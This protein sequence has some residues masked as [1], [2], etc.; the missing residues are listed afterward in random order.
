[1]KNTKKG[2]TLVELVISMTIVTI[3]VALSAAMIVTMSKISSKREYEDKCVD[4]YQKASALILD[5]KNAYSI[6]QYS[7]FSVEENEITIKS[8]TNDY[9]LNFN[10]ET[11]TLTAQIYNYE[12][13]QVD[14]KKI[15]FENIINISFVNTNNIVKCTYE[16]LNFHQYTNLLDFGVN[17]W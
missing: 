13:S 9:V 10:L 2:F 16:F 1:M 15:T 3:V 17:W 14:T 8:S 5:F 12:T 11:K 6:N 7:L 4:E